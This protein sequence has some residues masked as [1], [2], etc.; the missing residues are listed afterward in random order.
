MEW[1]KELLKK[2]GIADD[3][4]GK[5]D[6]E[7]R[8]ELPLH[9]IPKSQY[10]D[11]SE[12]KKKLETDLA[13]RD[14]QLE[15]IKKSAGDNEVLKKQIQTLQDENKTAKETYEQEMKSLRRD[16]ALKLQLGGKVHDPDIVLG[17]LDKDKIELDDDGN[18]KAG[19]DDQLKSLQESKGFLFVPEKE[20]TPPSFKG[21][22]PFEGESGGGEKDKGGNIGKMLADQSK[23]S[24]AS[25]Q[26]A[27]ANY[28]GGMK[29]E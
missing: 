16:T 17:L 22:K 12:A 26:Q 5:I 18:I 25:T 3:D 11:L 6:E 13:D 29:N 15:T 9:F 21:F 24:G 19:F 7:V 20:D 27:Q 23:Q 10:N 8:K 14:K 1:L 2:M 4:I 28:F